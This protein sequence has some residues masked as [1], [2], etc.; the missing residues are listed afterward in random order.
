M[1]RERNAS[2]S[3]AQQYRDA[4]LAP[5]IATATLSLTADSRSVCSVFDS[6]FV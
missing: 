3:V 6:K 2:I 1:C 4:A 5:V